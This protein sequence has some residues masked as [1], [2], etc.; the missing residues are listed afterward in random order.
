MALVRFDPPG[1][2]TDL[3]AAQVQ[4]W[5]DWVSQ[6]LDT[7]RE[8]DGSD[9]G[10]VNDGPR[11]QFFNPLKQAPAT[12]AIEKDITWTAF[13][14]IIGITSVSDLQRWRR[15]DNSRDVQD[16]Y[17]EWSVTR[18][19][20][21]HKIVRV[22]FTS[23][24]PEY[25]GFLAGVNPDK[26]VEL[27]R[28]HVNADVQRSDLFPNGIYRARNQWNNST[29][30]GAMH[31]IQASNTLDAEIELAAAA[32]IVRRKDGNILTSEQE[33]IGC[34]LYGQAARNSDPHIGAL[35]NELARQKAD[36]TLANPVGLYL[37]GLSVSGWDTPDGSNPLDYW[38]ITRGT[39]E[40]A[41]RAV[42]EVPEA[43][44]FKV[45]D[46]KINGNNIEFGA[47]IADFI[48]IKL[49]GLATRVGQSSVEAFDG[50]A[51]QVQPSPSVTPLSV[52]VALSYQARPAR[53]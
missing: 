45:G 26:V 10:L 36:I 53:R 13:P 9:E 8:R 3:D 31:L 33:L 17:C 48:T 49:T 39:K 14:R 28:Q 50:C 34:G 6:K 18:D 42:Y 4:A 12:D 11:H 35:V 15:A 52:A 25:W 44:S 23:E 38:K 1:F 51:K 22:T 20:Q 43:K 40:K 16:E 47:Q 27:Y 32:T 41:L 7:A 5:S 2:A 37:A 30:N 21:T 46:I 29:I 24:G 19:A